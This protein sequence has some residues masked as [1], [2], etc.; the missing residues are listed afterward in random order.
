MKAKTD[1]LEGGVDLVNLGDPVEPNDPEWLDISDGELRDYL[2]GS[3]DLSVTISHFIGDAQRGT[4]NLHALYEF[5][6]KQTVEITQ[7]DIHRFNV[8]AGGYT[9]Q[10]G[11][12]IGRGGY[13]QVYEL[14]EA[15]GH[16]EGPP[17]VLKLMYIRPEGRS[18]SVAAEIGTYKY[19]QDI[20]GEFVTAK[21][22]GGCVL[23]TLSIPRQHTPDGAIPIAI[24]IENVGESLGERFG[25]LVHEMQDVRSEYIDP[26]RALYMSENELIEA[27]RKILERFT[28]WLKNRSNESLNHVYEGFINTAKHLDYL[29]HSHIVHNDI[30]FAN[31]SHSGKL[32]DMGGVKPLVPR[33]LGHIGHMVGTIGYDTPFKHHGSQFYDKI[34]LDTY[35]FGYM[36]MQFL[37]YVLD[38]P[39]YPPIIFKGTNLGHE[40]PANTINIAEI[41]YAGYLALA[42]RTYKNLL[43]SSFWSLMRPVINDQVEDYPANFSMEQ[44]V[45]DV[46]EHFESITIQGLHESSNNAE[47]L[48]DIFRNK[49]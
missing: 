38:T 2:L 24:V 3:P 42:E 47:I 12:I 21:Y 32:F 7:E 39:G 44:V 36:I 1:T 35:A 29:H 23:G 40:L 4:I 27:D 15:E 30:K 18:L 16:N 13:G 25:E 6:D 48:F 26:E 8:R 19:L 17:A 37:Q 11:S 34:H 43:P 10:L 9:Y 28:T 5:F 45:R 22:Y 20:G 46:F 14:Q 41:D 33:D 49:S 31:I